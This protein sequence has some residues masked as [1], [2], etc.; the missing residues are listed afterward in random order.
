MSLTTLLF[1]G[2][3]GTPTSSGASAYRRYQAQ[4]GAYTL[5]T[6]VAQQKRL[7]QDHYDKEDED[8]EDDLLLS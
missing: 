5:S 8:D 1:Y 7:L 4:L 2:G 6:S 3:G